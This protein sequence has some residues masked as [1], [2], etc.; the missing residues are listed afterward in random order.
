LTNSFTDKILD[1]FPSGFV[2]LMITAGIILS[3]TSPIWFIIQKLLPSIF[4]IQPLTDTVATYGLLLAFSFI[5]GIPALLLE[6]SIIGDKG[7]NH[8]IK[9][10]PRTIKNYIFKPSENANQEEKEPTFLTIPFSKWLVENNLHWKVLNLSVKNTLINGL[11]LGFQISVIMNFFLWLAKDNS[12]PLSA[13]LT[14]L[15]YI[16]NIHGWWGSDATL[17]TIVVFVCLLLYNH[18]LWRPEFKSIRE[19]MEKDY[20]ATKKKT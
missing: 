11:V 13:L 20:E 4:Q 2:I 14:N 5:I 17:A 16:S 8:K 1:T 15:P 10:L 9:T 6:A 7:L 18:F 19:K 3:L 12:S